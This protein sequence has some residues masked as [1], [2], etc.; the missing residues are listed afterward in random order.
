[1]K[2]HRKGLRAA[3]ICRRGR[4]V[5]GKTSPQP[6]SYPRPPLAAGKAVSRGRSNTSWM[7]A[8]SSTYTRYQ[9]ENTAG[10][11]ILLRS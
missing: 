6:G 3:S 1:M 8:L 4:E 7:I 5:E 10:R 9:L 2:C 11:V